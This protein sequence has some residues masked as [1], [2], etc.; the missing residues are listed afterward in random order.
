MP[1]TVSTFKFDFAN[2]ADKPQESYLLTLGLDETI[3]GEKDIYYFD[4]EN[5]KWVAQHATKDQGAT[6]SIEVNH[7]S[8]YA[9]LTVNR[10][11]PKE[12]ESED[13]P[14]SNA[15]SE[16]DNNDSSNNLPE[17]A[18]NQFNLLLAGTVLL[19]IGI[20]VWLFRRKFN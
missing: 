18:T 2:S 1:V 12:E 19:L 17:T 10:E 16:K 13:N 3:A 14:S 11:D 6:L 15:G 7:F 20:G 5:D 4:K 9:V 8:S